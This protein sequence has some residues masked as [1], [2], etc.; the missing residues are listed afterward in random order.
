LRHLARRRTPYPSYGLLTWIGFV[1]AKKLAQP[2]TG[3]SK[4]PVCVIILKTTHPAPMLKA[5]LP[6]DRLLENRLAADET[7]TN[8][9]AAFIGSENRFQPVT[10]V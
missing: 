6:V 8:A 2:G 10:R 4:T 5:V 1:F 9:D 7:Q 3:G